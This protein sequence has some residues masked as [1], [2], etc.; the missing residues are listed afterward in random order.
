[1]MPLRRK[2]KSV[3]HINEKLVLVC[4]EGPS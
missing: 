1:V 3:C 2:P 4:R